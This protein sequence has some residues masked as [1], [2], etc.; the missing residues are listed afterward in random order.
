MGSVI[1]IGG[2]NGTG[3]PDDLVDPDG[4]SRLHIRNGRPAV[5]RGISSLEKAAQ[6]LGSSRKCGF[7]AAFYGLLTINT[8]VLLAFR[9]GYYPAEPYTQ[10]LTA[11]IQYSTSGIGVEPWFGIRNLTTGLAYST[12][13]PVTP[14]P[15]DMIVYSRTAVIDNIIIGTGA[16]GDFAMVPL[17]FEGTRVTK[18]GGT[19]TV[20]SVSIFP[21]QLGLVPI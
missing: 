19:V 5:A 17:D 8:P 9:L 20:Y 13:G 10:F 3:F 2:V 21:G 14:T 11:Y 18:A 6:V 16:P 12:T 7:P 15:F 1:R 4:P